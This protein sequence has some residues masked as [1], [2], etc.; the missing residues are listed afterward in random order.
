MSFRLHGEI[1][2]ALDIIWWFVGSWSHIY[3]DIA[4]MFSWLERLHVYMICF[5]EM[6]VLNIKKKH[7]SPD[8]NSTFLPPNNHNNSIRYFQLY[9]T[10]MFREIKDLSSK[11]FWLNHRHLLV[12]QPMGFHTIQKT[13]S[14]FYRFFFFW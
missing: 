6:V 9:W 1:I 8:H 3:H 11:S 10:N 4:Y 14:V 12:F 5:N 7:M 13:I 2:L